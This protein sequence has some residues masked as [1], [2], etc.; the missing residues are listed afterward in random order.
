MA[1]VVFTEPAEYDL[2]DIEYYIFVDL[3]NPQAAQRISDGIL[4]V[5]EKLSEYPTGHLPVDD[6]E[7]VKLL[8]KRLYSAH[9]LEESN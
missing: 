9:F 8:N 6:E 2:L 1:S 5:A 4:D 7:G 3:C